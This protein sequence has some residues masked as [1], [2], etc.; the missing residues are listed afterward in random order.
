MAYIN[1]GASGG[2]GGK[3]ELKGGKL[4]GDK[5]NFLE[6]RGNGKSLRG[7][8]ITQN[9]MPNTRERPIK[10]YYYGE[11]GPLPHDTK[12]YKDIATALLAAK[13]NGN[14]KE[15]VQIC[16]AGG[17]KDWKLATDKAN[18][19][20]NMKDNVILFEPDFV[21]GSATDKLWWK[22]APRGETWQS[23]NWRTRF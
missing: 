9:P 3:F 17:S 5:Y 2:F 15:N 12:R 7:L 16:L 18:M 14:W 10:I 8:E 22:S 20:A 19:E 11:P 21:C 13:N 4:G 23:G 1:A 6:F